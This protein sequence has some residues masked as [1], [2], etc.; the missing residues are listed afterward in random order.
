MIFYSKTNLDKHENNPVTFYLTGFARKSKKAYSECRKEEKNMNLQTIT[1]NTMI[2]VG[3]P[4]AKYAYKFAG[5]S[6]MTLLISAIITW[7]IIASLVVIALTL[8]K[9]YIQKRRMYASPNGRTKQTRKMRQEAARQEQIKQQNYYN[10]Q[11][12]DQINTAYQQRINQ[13]NNNANNQN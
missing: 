10:Q 7:L 9:R 12:K 6:K 11:R 5:K 1:A 8:L 13:Q 2:N 3:K 4:L